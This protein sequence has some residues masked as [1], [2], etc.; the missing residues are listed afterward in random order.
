MTH[1]KA[2]AKIITT[3]SNNSNLKKN[4][5]Q[6]QNIK[7]GDQQDIQSSIQLDIVNKM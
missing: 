5:T 4:N 7:Q 3:A 2:A 1:V 6:Y